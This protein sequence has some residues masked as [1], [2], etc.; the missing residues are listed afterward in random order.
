M[1]QIPQ[2]KQRYVKNLFL[3]PRIQW[4]IALLHI[5]LTIGFM[6]GI[7]Q[8]LSLAFGDIYN[9]LLESSNVSDQLQ[10]QVGLQLSGYRKLLL[11]LFLAYIAVN[12]FIVAYYTHKIIGPTIPM[13]RHVK[14]LIDNKYDSR[15]ILR[16]GDAFQDMAQDLNQLARLLEDR[17]D[18]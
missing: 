8:Y 12:V 6:L 9:V 16:K 3:L 2:S 18:G 15:V 13:K 1:S 17:R 5:L 14:C 11:V 7:A 10:A 4:K